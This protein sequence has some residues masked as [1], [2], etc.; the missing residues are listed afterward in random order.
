MK[1]TPWPNIAYAGGTAAPAGKSARASS[2]VTLEKKRSLLTITS[3]ARVNV[4][5]ISQ[6]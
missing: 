3:R 6:T 2:S 5:R 1:K 4:P